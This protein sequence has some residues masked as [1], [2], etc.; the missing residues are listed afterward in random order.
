MLFNGQ[1]LADMMNKKSKAKWGNKIGFMFIPFTIALQ[2][3]HP[4]D[5]LRG[6]KAIAD[7]KKLS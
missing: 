4:L 5:Y 1:A 3:D 6:A 7:R 2:N